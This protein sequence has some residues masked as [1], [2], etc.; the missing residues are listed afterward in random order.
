MTASTETLYEGRFLKL[1]RRGRWEYVARV[2]ACGAVHILAITP[3]NELLMVEQFRAPVGARVL[4]LP[5]GI[6]GDQPELRGETPEAAAAREL[7]EETGYRPGRVALLYRGPSSPGMA[8]ELVTVVRASDLER[9]GEG[10]G[11]DG[12]DIR[13]HR[14]PLPGVRAWLAQRAADGWAIDHKVYAALFFLTDAV[15][16]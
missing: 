2:G 11:V 16:S 5:A 12:E 9:V 15:K 3:E 1:L 14:I 7:A 13:V 8:S 6:V 4:E 10:G